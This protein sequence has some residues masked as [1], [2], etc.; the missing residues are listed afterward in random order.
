MG[1]SIEL[2]VYRSTAQQGY[3]LN[4]SGARLFPESQGASDMGRTMSLKGSAVHFNVK[5]SGAQSAQI[6]ASGLLT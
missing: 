2:C 4:A 1:W 5:Q 3:P 6:P